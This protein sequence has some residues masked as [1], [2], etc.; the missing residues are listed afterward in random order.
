MTYDYN[1]PKD[2]NASKSL[3]GERWGDDAGSGEGDNFGNSP[4]KSST[5]RSDGD[6]PPV[7]QAS[8]QTGT[9]AS[10]SSSSKLKLPNFSEVKLPKLKLPKSMERAGSA[11][12]R[13]GLHTAR[14]GVLVVEGTFALSSLILTTVGKAVTSPLSSI[15]GD[16]GAIAGNVVDSRNNK[17]SR[18]DDSATTRYR[19]IGKDIGSLGFRNLEEASDVAYRGLEKMQKGLK[20]KANDY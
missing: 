12:A 3:W 9:P 17:R 6:S 7:E 11:A 16:L 20:K 19:E 18:D 4:T 1:A 10:N 14:A 15:V 13:V 5:K 8:K 2:Y